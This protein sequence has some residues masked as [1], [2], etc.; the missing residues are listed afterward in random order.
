M[1]LDIEEDLIIRREIRNNGSSRSFINDSPVKIDQLKFISQYI[2][3][4]N[5][6]HLINKMGSLNFKYEFLDSFLDKKNTLVTYKNAYLNL[7]GANFPQ[8]QARY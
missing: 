2:I 5:G 1:D 6:Q 4:I 3:E 8:Y 7:A